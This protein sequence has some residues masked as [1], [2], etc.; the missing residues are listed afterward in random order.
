MVSKGKFFASDEERV[1]FERW[2]LGEWRKGCEKLLYGRSHDEEEDAAGAGQ[3]D[4]E[5]DE[6]NEKNNQLL[7]EEPEEEEGEGAE[8]ELIATKAIWITAHRL[9]RYI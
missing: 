9:Q 7:T 2:L 8:Q 4:I 5:D 6:E 1:A 3:F